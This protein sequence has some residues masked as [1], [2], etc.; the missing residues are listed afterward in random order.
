MSATLLANLTVFFL[1]LLVGFEVISKVPAML[2]TPLM[3][4]AN[5]IHGIVIVGAMLVAAQA[6]N[7]RGVR[8]RVCR[9]RVRFHERH[10]RV[11][12][13]RPHAADV[14]PPPRRAPQAGWRRPDRRLVS[15]FDT[16]VRLV[17]L[18]VAG[19][20][21]LGLHMMNSPATAKRGDRL[22]ATGMTAAVLTTVA[23]IVHDGS[24][25]GTGWAC[26]RGALLGSAIGF[27]FARTV[28]MT[29]IPQLVSLFNA[30]GGGAAAV[31]GISEFLRVTGNGARAPVHVIVATVFDVF[32]G[33]VTFSGSLVAAGKLQGDNFGQPLVFR[34]ARVVT[35]ALVLLVVAGLVMLLTGTG[36]LA[37]LMVIVA[38]SLVLGLTM[39]LPMVGPTC[40]WSS[41]CSTLSPGP[42]SR[43][44]ASSSTT[45]C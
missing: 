24:I 35:S 5:S 6:H 14:P 9:G 21:V 11:R 28:A 12:G 38:A 2:H 1:S 3:S 29:A 40:R 18:V 27:R 26:W 41:R 13:H 8:A 31:V 16:A 45:P 25:D 17:Y 33:G 32:I 4:A 39:V 34:G 37:L 36:G 10:R 20:L 19:A 22:S 23:V 42:R 43:W 7:P 15:S 44:P 30:V